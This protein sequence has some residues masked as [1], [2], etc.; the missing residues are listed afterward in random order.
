MPN[1][2]ISTKKAR[3]ELGD[4]PF[5]AFCRWL[6]EKGY[7]NLTHFGEGHYK[8]EILATKDQ[9]H[10]FANETI[11]GNHGL[12]SLTA[13]WRQTRDHWRGLKHK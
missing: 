6:R 5:F 3:E 1:E 11:G 12:L 13:L 4:V 9:L 2:Y 7:Q 10:H 8:H